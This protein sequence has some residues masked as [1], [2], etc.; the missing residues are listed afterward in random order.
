MQSLISSVLQFLLF[1]L[2]IG[3]FVVFV[4]LFPGSL[5]SCVCLAEAR[6]VVWSSG[7]ISSLSEL[8][9]QWPVCD[10]VGMSGEKERESAG[11]GAWWPVIR[12][13][14]LG[15]QQVALWCYKLKE[16]V[17]SNVISI[18]LLQWTIFCYFNVSGLEIMVVTWYMQ[19]WSM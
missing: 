11:W 17:Y 14:C 2:I 3:L 18:N 5:S 4:Y 1:M 9:R 19:C 7:C 10:E 16:C 12:P 13:T 6:Q 8:R 15:L